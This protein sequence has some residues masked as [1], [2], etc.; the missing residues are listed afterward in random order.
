M[1]DIQPIKPRG[2]KIYMRTCKRTG[3]VFK[4][5]SKYALYCPEAYL[6]H[7]LRKPKAPK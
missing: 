7:K 3:K 6:D 4:T 5:N 1:I 2:F